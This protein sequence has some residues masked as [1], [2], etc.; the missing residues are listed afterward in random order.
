MYIIFIG[1]IFTYVV[2]IFALYVS[3]L[4]EDVPDI[5]YCAVKSIENKGFASDILDRIDGVSPAEIDLSQR[6]EELE[7]KE[8]Q[9]KS[10]ICI[11]ETTETGQ[12]I[13]FT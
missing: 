6:H 10:V 8:M 5:S 7:T 11:N 12:V 3:V 4:A 2:L 1:A 9:R 13:C